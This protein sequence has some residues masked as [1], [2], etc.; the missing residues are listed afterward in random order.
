MEL[1]LA[2]IE[3]QEVKSL[4]WAIVSAFSWFGLFSVSMGR[5]W[6]LVYVT[7]ALQAEPPKWKKGS[8]FL[9]PTFFFM[10]SHNIIQRQK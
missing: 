6:S 8:L 4:Y 5:E 10:Y 9:Y 7:I 1:Q 2:I 3:V